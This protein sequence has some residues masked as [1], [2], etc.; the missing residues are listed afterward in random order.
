[1]Q[2]TLR[3]IVF[4]LVGVSVQGCSTLREGNVTDSNKYK[5][6]KT[7]REEL[8]AMYNG[9]PGFQAPQEEMW[10]RI[11][12]LPPAERVKAYAAQASEYGCTQTTL[13]EAILWLNDEGKIDVLFYFVDQ[14]NLAEHRKFF[15]ILD[16]TGSP[17]S[18]IISSQHRSRKYD[19]LKM[20]PS[21]YMSHQNEIESKTIES[22]PDIGGVRAD[23][24]SIKWGDRLAGR[25]N[26]L[27][28]P[29]VDVEGT[30][31][32]LSKA[33]NCRQT[34]KEG[35]IYWYDGDDKI[36]AMFSFLK[37]NDLDAIRALYKRIDEDDCPL[38]WVF[39]RLTRYDN[40][41]FDIFRVHKNHYMA[42]NNRFG[43]Y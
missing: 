16:Q 17:L 12:D 1:M 28:K 27:S 14:R 15:A 18:Y 32:E 24:L 34:I 19:V 11:F 40:P 5:P 39:L 21:Y 37:D 3:T 4:I 9:G 26:F 33:F 22:T 31:A 38:T 8:G 43:R 29:F 20:T 42:H 30:Y 23:L 35:V 10:G 13:D 41:V 2:L 36:Q 6:S 7:I 25:E